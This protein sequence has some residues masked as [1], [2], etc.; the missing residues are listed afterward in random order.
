MESENWTEPE[1]K[2]R[3][4]IEP[5]V[6]Q[7]NWN[8][9]AGDGEP[10]NWTKPEA[11]QG[12]W[13]EPEGEAEPGNWTEPGEEKGPWNREWVGIH[14]KVL[15]QKLRQLTMTGCSIHHFDCKTMGQARVATL[16]TA[17]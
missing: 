5:E 7:G 13:T 14:F 9:P 10:G 17:N 15:E 16:W 4:W 8:E 3:N 11:E 12:N 6:E 1:A 2:P